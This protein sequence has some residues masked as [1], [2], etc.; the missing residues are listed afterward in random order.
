MKYFKAA[1]LAVKLYIDLRTDPFFTKEHDYSEWREW[2]LYR[3]YKYQLICIETNKLVAS[4][5]KEHDGV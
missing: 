5:F 1:A 2:S 4:I 3:C